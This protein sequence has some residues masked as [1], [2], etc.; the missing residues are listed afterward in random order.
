[1]KFAFKYM[2]K[3]IKHVYMY[4]LGWRLV[5]GNPA[6][7]N[8]KRCIS[9]KLHPENLSVVHIQSFISTINCTHLD[10]S[11]LSNKCSGL[12]AIWELKD[13]VAL[14]N[15]EGKHTDKVIASMGKC[16][17]NSLK[18]PPWNTQTLPE[19]EL[20][21][22]DCKMFRVGWEKTMKLT[23][24]CMELKKCVSK[25]LHSSSSNNHKMSAWICYDCTHW[26]G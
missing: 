12:N 3:T 18:L 19:S 17:P 2:C 5:N 9:S 6:R 22:I 14:N 4:V 10:D 26:V 24:G 25:K 13:W 23:W 11:E 1:M 7:N 15:C 16:C 8:R 20:I 21:L